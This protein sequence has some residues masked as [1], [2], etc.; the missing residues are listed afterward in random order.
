MS[1]RVVRLANATR[2]IMGMT[3][4]QDW[5]KKYKFSKRTGYRQVEQRNVSI[6]KVGAL[7]Y[8]SD[9]DDAAF[10]AKLPKLDVSAEAIEQRRLL[11]LRKQ[12]ETEQHA[13]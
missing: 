6:T 4:F 7:S 5:C 8:V 3:R 12:A 13:T 2:R 9:E 10:Q 1:V 11:H